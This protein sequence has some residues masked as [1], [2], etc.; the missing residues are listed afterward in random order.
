MTG[1]HCR[2]ALAQNRLQIGPGDLSGLWIHSGAHLVQQ[3]KILVG[4]QR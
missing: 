3:N 1:E 4:E 2:T